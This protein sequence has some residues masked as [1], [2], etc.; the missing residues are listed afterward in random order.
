MTVEFGYGMAFVTGI[1]GAFHCLG[2]CGT[3]AGGFFIGHGG[4]NK[5]TPQLAYHLV[6]ILTYMLLGMSSAFAGQVLA[7]VG[8]VGK[9][10]GML[11][12]LAGLVII[13]TGLW[14][15]DFLPGNKRKS[16]NG[17]CNPRG[18]EDLR[19]GNYLPLAAGLINGLVPCSLVFS[20]AIKT[21]VTPNVLEAGLLM[22]FF[23]LGTLPA[24]LLV[25][26]SGSWIGRKTTGIF[27]PLTGLLVIAMG[28]WTTY[29]GIVFYDIM[30]GLAN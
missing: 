16:C 4:K 13:M 10:Q 25:T 15:G 7:Q 5:L 14:V 28:L 9:G 21:L 2:M 19:G 22:L 6:R 11:M 12:I 23:G 1:A 24:M 20:M 8:I 3:F 27:I 18:F 17:P 26:L 30:R 29:E